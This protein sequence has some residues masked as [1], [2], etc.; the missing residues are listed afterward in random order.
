MDKMDKEEI[1][2][3]Y[4][5]NYEFENDVKVEI[6][7]QG[8]IKT[9]NKLHPKGKLIKGT[10]QGGFPILRIKLNKPKKESEI[11]KIAKIQSEIDV[12]NAK[13]KTEPSKDVKEI[14]RKER[15]R[16][17]Q[18]RATY[19]KKINLKRTINVGIL[20][21]KA[22]AELFLEKPKDE[23]KKFIIHKDFDKTNNHVENL[24]WAS[25]EELNERCKNHPKNILYAFKKQFEP[26]VPNVKASKLTENEV[27]RIKLRLKKGDSLKKLANQ[28]GVSDMQIHRIKT[29]ENW[30]HVK[31]LE[32]ILEETK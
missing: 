14:L 13:I 19:N 5:L 9:Y 17:I 32:D 24:A 30:S 21:H 22:V 10:L 27:L 18:K 31:L 1:W 29:G 16:L 28:F 6:S 4:P 26:K 25:Q 8:K 23:S 20:I 7:N 3:E 12:L 2:K 11:L 15:D